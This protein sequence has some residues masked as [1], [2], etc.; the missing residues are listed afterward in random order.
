MEN[1]DKLKEIVY[2]C[3]G[4]Q[5]YKTRHNV[6]FGD[7]NEQ[8]HIM[9]IGEGPGYNEDMQGKPFVGKSGQLFDKIL[10]AVNLTR[11]DIYIANIVKCRP[12]QNRNPMEEECQSCI[13]YL[14]WQV[15]FIQPEIIVCLGVV[16]AKHII[17]K[18]FKIT[19]KHGRWYKRSKFNIMATYHPSALL[20]DI[21]KKKAAWEDFKAIR[22]LYDELTADQ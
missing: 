18:D 5:L 1:M 16:A 15:K 20:R 14:R 17:D 19:Q 4:C 6:V 8:A 13:N 2:K 10:A 9:F 22:K 7:G 21:N 11:A 3:Q 12:P